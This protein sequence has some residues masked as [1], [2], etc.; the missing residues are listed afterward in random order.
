[1]ENWGGKS[2]DQSMKNLLNSM[3][4]QERKPGGPYLTSNL[5]LCLAA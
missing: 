4:K 1:M 3:R 5:G 2:K